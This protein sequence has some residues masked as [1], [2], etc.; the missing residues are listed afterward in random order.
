MRSPSHD[1]AL[2]FVDLTTTNILTAVNAMSRRSLFFLPKRAID[3]S[4]SPFAVHRS[5]LSVH[6]PQPAIGEATCNIGFNN[7]TD[8]LAWGS[9]KG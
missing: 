6:S 7:L 8:L 2:L 1:R 4:G 3:H 9:T 5:R